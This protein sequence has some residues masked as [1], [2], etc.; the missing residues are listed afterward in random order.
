MPSAPGRA[1]VV[2]TFACLA[3]RVRDVGLA[4]ALSEAIGL[5]SVY[6]WY[7]D[8]YRPLHPELFDSCTVGLLAWLPLI[9]FL[10]QLHQYRFE[11]PQQ[12]QCSQSHHFALSQALA[13]DC[14]HAQILPRFQ[15]HFHK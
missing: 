11:L 3:V 1:V 13:Y 15:Y 5:G 10:V 12:L 6:E 9:S 2:A 7:R 14:L 8:A 4:A